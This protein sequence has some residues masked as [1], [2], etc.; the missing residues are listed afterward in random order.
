M[1]LK[2]SNKIKVKVEDIFKK[3]AASPSPPAHLRAEGLAVIPTHTWMPK[4]PILRYSH[5]TV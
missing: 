2:T 3:P 1:F 5:R 4:R